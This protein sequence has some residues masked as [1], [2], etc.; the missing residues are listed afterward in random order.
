MAQGNGGISLVTKKDNTFLWHNMLEHM[1]L[2]GLQILSQ[3]GLLEGDQIT[4]ME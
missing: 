2:I 1:S 4:K 3:Q